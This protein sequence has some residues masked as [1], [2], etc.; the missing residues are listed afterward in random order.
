MAVPLAHQNVMHRNHPMGL[1]GHPCE[2]VAFLHSD[3]FAKLPFTLILQNWSGLRAEPF[4]NGKLG[5]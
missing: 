2:L 4:Q 3:P 5:A 1:A